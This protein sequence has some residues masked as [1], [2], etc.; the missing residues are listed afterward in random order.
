M[1][2]EQI[3]NLLQKQL[4]RGIYIHDNFGITQN[5]SEQFFVKEFDVTNELIIDILDSNGYTIPDKRDFIK[6][7][8]LLFDI[9][10]E[11]SSDKIF[12]SYPISEFKPQ[13]LVFFNKRRRSTYR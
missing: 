2:T 4:D 3:E 12:Y 6:R 5:Y 7:I 13:E 8:K 9:D 11:S 1:N 10:I